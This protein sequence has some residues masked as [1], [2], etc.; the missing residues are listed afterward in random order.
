[1]NNYSTC[2]VLVVFTIRNDGLRKAFTSLLDSS[3]SFTNVDQSSY[4]WRLPTECINVGSII[5]KLTKYASEAKTASGQSYG[6]EDFIDFYVSG[7]FAQ[8]DRGDYHKL[9]KY[10]IIN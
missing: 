1:M 5:S 8:Q 7:N 4:E 10:H 2:D 3:N 9:C 6:K